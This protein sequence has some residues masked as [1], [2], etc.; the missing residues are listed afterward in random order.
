[1]TRDHTSV[2]ER[3]ASV[4]SGPAS[5]QCIIYIYIYNTRYTFRKIKTTTNCESEHFVET[6]LCKL[7]VI[8]LRLR[9]LRVQ[10]DLVQSIQSVYIY[11]KHNI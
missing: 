1:M 5:F 3:S 4:V 10:D 2:Y 7:C 6:H 9:A 8:L 11:G